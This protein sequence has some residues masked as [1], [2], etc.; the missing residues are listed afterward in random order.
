MGRLP[1]N[2]ERRNAGLI[3]DF[4]AVGLPPTTI[5]LREGGPAT[6]VKWCVPLLPGV[7]LA[8]GVKWCVP[9]LPGVLLVDSYSVISPSSGSGGVKVVVYYG[10]GA[11]V[12]CELW[13]WLA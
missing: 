6:G 4:R 1:E 3:A 12:V 2:R 9:L 11:V 7:L 10:T 5:D 8:T 13:G